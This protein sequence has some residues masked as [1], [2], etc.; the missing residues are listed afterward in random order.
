[1]MRTA[2]ALLAAWFVCLPGT[3]WADDMG[4]VLHFLLTGPVALVTGGLELLVVIRTADRLE[5]WGRSPDHTWA[6]RVATVGI[7]V[8]VVLAAITASV[9][10]GSDLYVNRGK[11]MGMAT[12]CVSPHILLAL[13]GIG[14]GMALLRKKARE[15]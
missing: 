8:P 2:A 7:V 9:A 4:G 5:K 15:R 12:A 13:V 3:A 6:P 10:W 11:H 14:L 1:M